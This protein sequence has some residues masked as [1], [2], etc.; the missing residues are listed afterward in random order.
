MCCTIQ[1]QYGL[2]KINVKAVTESRQMGYIDDYYDK[3]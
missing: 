2:T 3:I 1:K